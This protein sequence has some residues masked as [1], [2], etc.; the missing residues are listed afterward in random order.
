MSDRSGYS[1]A[2]PGP[3]WEFIGAVP[4]DQLRKG[5]VVPFYSQKYVVLEPA[6]GGMGAYFEVLNRSGKDWGDPSYMHD[7]PRGVWDVYRKISEEQL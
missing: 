3:G 2:D 1:E 4:W 5:D 7:V 6:A